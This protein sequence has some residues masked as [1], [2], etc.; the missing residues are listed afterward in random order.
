M[1]RKEKFIPLAILALLILQGCAAATPPRGNSAPI[2]LEKANLETVLEEQ[3][4]LEI[5]PEDAKELRDFYRGG[6]Q[7][8]AKAEKKFQ[9]KSYSEALKL[10]DSSN[11][12][13]FVVIK[14]NDMDNAEFPLFEGT[15]ILFF[16][17]LLVADNFLKAGRILQEMKRDFW[18]K[19]KWKQARSYVTESLKSEPTEWGLS[20]QQELAVLLDSKGR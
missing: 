5:I 6:V 12:F 10:Y 14:H 11:E 18:A 20:L 19:R 3:E 15:S 16:P 7:Q 17:N 13:F 8:K 4:G 9:E 1:S 2:P